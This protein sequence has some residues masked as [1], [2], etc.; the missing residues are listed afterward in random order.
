MVIDGFEQIIS[1]GLFFLERTYLESI[2]GDL[3]QVVNSDKDP[4]S[5]R[6]RPR[7]LRPAPPARLYGER[8]PR[9]VD[10]R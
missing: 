7:V 3:S 10:P 4:R 6:R 1:D 5:P 8:Q 2:F 9:P